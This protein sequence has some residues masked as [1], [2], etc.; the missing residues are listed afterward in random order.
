MTP[1][2]FLSLWE[3]KNQKAMQFDYNVRLELGVAREVARKDLPLSTYTEAYW[4]CDLH[5]ILHFLG[6]RMDSHAQKEI[7]DYATVIGEQ[8]IAPLFPEVWAAFSDYRLNGM[9][10]TG[11]DKIALRDL[12]QDSAE[13]LPAN[14]M[15]VVEEIRSG[16]FKHVPQDW[17]SEKCRE[18]DE[19]I[20]K[21]RSLG[22]IVG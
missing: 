14:A 22:L 5:N 1:G 11:P 3:K 8:I 16:F 15:H 21:M 17:M 7:R 6:L 9:F 12:M 20:E 18:R 4:K 13:P 10:L 19:F 2:Q